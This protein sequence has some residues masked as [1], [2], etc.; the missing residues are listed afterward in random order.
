MA[1]CLLL[2]RRHLILLLLLRH[3]LLCRLRVLCV[4]EPLLLLPLLQLQHV[5]SLASRLLA[6]YLLA[7]CCLLRQLSVER[8]G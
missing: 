4:D 8:D 3:R 7:F 2:Q 6:L 5:L 1:Q